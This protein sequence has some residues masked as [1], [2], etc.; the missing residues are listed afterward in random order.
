MSIRR[1]TLISALLLV[2][3]IYASTACR[4][5]ADPSWLR[6]WNEAQEGRP[7]TLTSSGRIA[8]ESEP[9]TPLT[10]H[11]EVL[12]PDGTPAGGVVVHA[13]H[14]DRDGFDFGPNDAS[15]TTWRLQGWVKT[16]AKGRFDLLTIR[17]APDHLGREGAHIHF[18]LES[19]DFG[20]QWAA[21]VFFLDDPL[22]TEDQRRRSKEAGEFGWLREVREVD[23]V[24]H[25]DVRFRLKETGDF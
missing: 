15:L 13:Y 25:V 5:Q 19:A 20:R 7:L 2:G 17:P 24:Q 3:M 9:G 14:R 18:T 6:S 8:E 1:A 4:S 21:T 11:G 12:K 16:D 22:V 10:V 23:G